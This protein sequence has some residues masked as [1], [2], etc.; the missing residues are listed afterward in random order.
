MVLTLFCGHS[1][2]KFKKLGQVILSQ[3][4]CDQNVDSKKF[5]LSDWLLRRKSKTLGLMTRGK[6]QAK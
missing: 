5:D 6:V 2:S 4:N 1:A 3:V